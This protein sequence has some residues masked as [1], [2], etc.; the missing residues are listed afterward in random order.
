M[1]IWKTCFFA[2]LC[3]ALMT[4][5]A[6][7]A[8]HV[9][10]VVYGDSVIVEGHEVVCVNEGGAKVP[11]LRYNGTTYIPVRTAG[12]WM[13]KQVAWDGASQT[14]TLS[15]TA[16]QIFRDE[17]DYY[18]A[19]SEIPKAGFAVH[20]AIRPDLTIVVDA[21]KKNFQNV[22]GEPVYPLSYNDVTYLPL[23]N[24]GEMIN[25]E[26]AW[27]KHAELDEE[28]IY[29]RTPMTT[30]QKNACES[31]LNTLLT[32]NQKLNQAA[33]GLRTA[34]TAQKMKTNAEQAEAAITAIKQTAMPAGIQLF[35]V[36]KEQM[37][38]KL[39]EVKAELDLVFAALD[40][41]QMEKAK[42]HVGEK[43]QL[44]VQ[45]AENNIVTMKRY[46]LQKPTDTNLL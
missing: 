39:S 34:D 4:C 45:F 38:K 25:M 20:A 8:T 32:Q 46:Y 11:Y 6:F 1:K 18:S 13:G 21:Q 31:Y 24:I 2:A 41:G 3:S 40:N 36:Q 44:G 7:A 10:P 5:M 27:W 30:A 23:R 37:E 42:Q 35:S 29:I 33:T 28:C 22:Q 14:V 26:V 15:G 9:A 17:E 16:D 19:P 12:E 43:F